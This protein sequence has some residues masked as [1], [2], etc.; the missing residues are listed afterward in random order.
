MTTTLADIE[1]RCAVY[2]TRRDTLAD[3]LQAL[4]DAVT[5]L[6]RRHLPAVRAAYADLA[7]EETLLRDDLEQ[8]KALF[9]KP[10]TRVLH[11]IK[12]GWNKG[13]PRL[14]WDDPAEVVARINRLLADQAPSLIRR[15]A[16]Q[17]IKK[18]LETLDAKTL[19]RIGVRIT[20][21]RDALV[22][23]PVDGDIDKLINTLL[24]DF[25]RELEA[26]RGERRKAA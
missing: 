7:A 5:T 22:I 26:D 16:P 18:A 3:R 11:G 20:G 19:G 10:R 8:A 25:R 9:K 21:G 12:V 23:K 24:G 1:A 4:E 13:K 6:K 14:D 15:P 2:R 17:P